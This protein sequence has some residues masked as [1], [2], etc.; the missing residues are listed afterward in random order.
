MG[1]NLDEYEPVDRRIARFWDDN[2]DGQIN[3]YAVEVTDDTALFRAAVWVSGHDC[4]GPATATGWAYERRSDGF[5]NQTSH[6]ENAETSAIGRA[7][8]NL[9]YAT[10]GKRPSQEEMAHTL[11][12]DDP[13]TEGQRRVIVEAASH[14]TPEQ[15][16]EV[17]S[18]VTGKDST[19]DLVQRD[20]TP[21]MDALRAEKG[22]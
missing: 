17:I 10:T 18:R 9:G 12:P 21:V 20:L 15:A 13:A 2:P 1:F 3:T 19:A 4:D 7:L 16:K 22:D 11:S 5:V 8:A 14:L 6:V